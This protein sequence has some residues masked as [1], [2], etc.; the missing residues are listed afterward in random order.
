MLIYNYQVQL[1]QNI[2]EMTNEKVHASKKY[3]IKENLKTL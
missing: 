3:P 2:V 1:F